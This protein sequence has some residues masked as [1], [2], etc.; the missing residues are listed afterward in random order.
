[1]KEDISDHKVWKNKNHTTILFGCVCALSTLVASSK[2]FHL[3]LLVNSV[4]H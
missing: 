3:V 4:L 1:M 2:F